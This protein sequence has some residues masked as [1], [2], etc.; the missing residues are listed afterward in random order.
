M[1]EEPRTA[2]GA[3]AGAARLTDLLHEAGFSRVRL[4][5]TTPFNL[6]IEARP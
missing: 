6:V 4:A 5:T 1:S 3:Q 2:L